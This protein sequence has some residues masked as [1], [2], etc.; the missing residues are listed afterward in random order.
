VEA[1]ANLSYNASKI[2][3]SSN[4]WWCLLTKFLPLRCTK[5][6]RCQSGIWWS[7][8]Q[9]TA[10]HVVDNYLNSFDSED[11][12]IQDLVW[13]RT[14][15]TIPSTKKKIKAGIGSKFWLVFPWRGCWKI[16]KTIKQS[17][18]TSSLSRNHRYIPSASYW[19]PS[20]V[21]WPYSLYNPVVLDGKL[22]FQR[23]WRS[24]RRLVQNIA[25]RHFGILESLEQFYCT[26]KSAGRPVT[27][28]W[29]RR[30]SKE[31]SAHLLRCEKWLL[32]Q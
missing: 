24:K 4:I 21:Y 30:R 11:T 6:V 8:L 16:D 26:P 22:L 14:L 32:E 17:L 15:P 7:P 28:R 25:E 3:Q 27:R 31:T 20:S 23:G 12:K 18:S 29:E 10:Q 9:D 2:Y 1:T 5:D 13:T 19:R